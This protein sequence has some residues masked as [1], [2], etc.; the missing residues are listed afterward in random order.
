[1]ERT[2]AENAVTPELMKIHRLVKQ[3]KRNREVS[4]EYMKIYEREQLLIQQGRDEERENTKRALEEAERERTRAEAAE[5][6]LKLLR[7][8]LEETLSSKPSA[9]D[10]A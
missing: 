3:V 8:Q 7:I 5:K 4:L 6:E 9:K 1:M 10:D 2:T